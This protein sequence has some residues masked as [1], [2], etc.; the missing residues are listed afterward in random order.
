MKRGCRVAAP[1]VYLPY[2]LESFNGILMLMVRYFDFR[3]KYQITTK[4]TK[5]HGIV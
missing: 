2:G 4:G 5:N 1:F 3:N